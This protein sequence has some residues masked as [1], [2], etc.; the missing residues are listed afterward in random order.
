MTRRSVKETRHDAGSRILV[1]VDT[2]P[3]ENNSALQRTEQFARMAGSTM[4]LLRVTRGHIVPMGI[5]GGSS[6]AVV[7]AEYDADNPDGRWSRTRWTGMGVH[8]HPP[9]S[10]L[11][12]RPSQRDWAPVGSH[13]EELPGL[14][15]TVSG[16][17]DERPE[18]RR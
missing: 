17:P 14:S 6:R 10:I 3:D 16:Q 4:Y 8:Q 9:Y 13:L 11:L 2:T 5:I 1:A 15:V 18:R 7:S 12:A